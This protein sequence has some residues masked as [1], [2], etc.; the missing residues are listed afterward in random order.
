LNYNCGIN[1]KQNYLYPLYITTMNTQHILI[2]NE[3]SNELGENK[4]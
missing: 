3:I 1:K 2:L 4:S